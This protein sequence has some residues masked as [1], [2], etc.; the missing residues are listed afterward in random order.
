MTPS[1]CT[2]KECSACGVKI[3][4]DQVL[5]SFGTPGSKERLYARVC[6]FAKKPGCINTVASLDN[7]KSNDFYNNGEAI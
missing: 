6:Q 1:T 4:G 7:C 3:V 2:P 5:F